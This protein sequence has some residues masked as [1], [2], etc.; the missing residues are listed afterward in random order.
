MDPENTNL[1]AELE[2]RLRF[3]TL[4]TALSSKFVNLPPREVDREIKDAQ[5][6]LCELLGLDMSF[7]WQ[8]SDETPDYFNLN[9]FYTV[10]ELP[11]HYVLPTQDDFPWYKQQCL[12]GRV[13]AMSSLEELPAEAARDREVGRQLGVKAN[14]SFP[15]SVGGGQIFGIFSV[16]STRAEGGWP[17]ALVKRLQLLAQV[18][19]NALAR[20][21]ADQALRESE[22]R[23]SLAVNSAQAGIWVLDCRTQVFWAT[24]KA[25]LIFGYS[26]EEAINLERFKG[27]V[28][29]D[30]WNL[31]QTSLDRAVQ[32]GEPVNVEYRIRLG[33]GAERWI[34]SRGRP[35]F[36][37]AG[38]PERLLGVSTDIT[39]RKRAE[40]AFRVSEARLA[41]GA[42]L[43]G[44]GYYE[45]DYGKRTCFLD[46]RVRE[47]CGVPGDRQAGFQ[48]LEVWRC[49]RPSLKRTRENSGRKIGGRRRVFRFH[50]ACGLW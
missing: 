45:V 20:K 34:S 10:Q 29:P 23:L 18:F 35:H 9:H 47:I 50:P 28:H 42:E 26:P 16:V 36:T 6:R 39:E 41:A 15:L 31:V 17:D 22:E 43:A 21:R 32:A 46:D 8:R 1:R 5:R 14:L 2:E 30:D 49:R 24:E 44:L 33:D 3:E 11:Q 25:R 27:T 12:A 13:L 48:S 40:E 4:I 38:E 19:A 37:S 7:F